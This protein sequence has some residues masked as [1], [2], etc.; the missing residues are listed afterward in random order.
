MQWII[1]TLLSACLLFLLSPSNFSLRGDDGDILNEWNVDLG[2]AGYL[3][4]YISEGERKGLWV[5]FPHSPISIQNSKY[6]TGSS[7]IEIARRDLRP[8]QD[9][10]LGDQ[11]E[12]TNWRFGGDADMR[13]ADLAILETKIGV[14]IRGL[15][16]RDYLMG[17]SITIRKGGREYYVSEI[18]NEPAFGKNDLQKVSFGVRSPEREATNSGKGV[19][20]INSYTIDGKRTLVA[21]DIFS[22]VVDFI[23]PKEEV[24]RIPNGR[25]MTKP[26]QTSDGTFARFWFF[27]DFP[28][29]KLPLKNII[30]AEGTSWHAS[31]RFLTKANVQ[32]S[33]SPNG[34]EMFVGTMD[35]QTRDQVR[36]PDI[37]LHMKESSKQVYGVAS[38]GRF[39]QYFE[40]GDTVKSVNAIDVENMN[41]LELRS[42]LE[43]C[44]KT[45]GAVEILR[46]GNYRKIEI[47]KDSRSISDYIEAMFEPLGAK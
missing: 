45:G 22:G 14:S 36:L 28:F 30:V 35:Q 37:V 7:S 3:T 31:L 11:P 8:R 2:D 42:M 10:M 29:D 41:S 40:N 9:R 6:R 34:P 15:I 23:I 32:L 12:I 25:P 24:E 26:I 19:E 46:G 47:Q 44:A 13:S 20:F 39:S 16:G 1:R 5:I 43:R 17:K 21:L 4:T 38:N 18:G 33:F 27:E